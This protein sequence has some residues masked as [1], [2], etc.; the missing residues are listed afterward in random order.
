M[1]YV[2]GSWVICICCPWISRS[3]S[4]RLC[5]PPR[6]TTS[7]FSDFPLGACINLWLPLTLGR[8]PG[9]FLACIWYKRQQ[10][11]GFGCLE[12]SSFSYRADGDVSAVPV[13]CVY[14]HTYSFLSSSLMGLAPSY[15]YAHIYTHTYIFKRIN[16]Y[17]YLCMYIYVCVPVYIHLMYIYTYLNIYVC[18]CVYFLIDRGWGRNVSSIIP[19]S[20]DRSLKKF[21]F[22]P[23]A[24][25]SRWDALGRAC[26][27]IGNRV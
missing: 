21:S 17:I 25:T 7:K 8:P 1:G 10:G 5:R 24:L 19:V 6:T 16:I 15:I 27:C 12:A 26:R 22:C 23:T 9:P 18:V 4:H 14:V 20:E 2:S 13:T 11:L 3:W